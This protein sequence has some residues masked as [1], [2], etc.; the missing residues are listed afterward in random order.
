M[1]TISVVILNYNG[2]KM[3][4]KYL[5][6]VVSNTKDAEIIVA[7]N[8]ST[9]NSITWIKNNYPSIRIIEMSE[10]WGFAEGYNKALKQVDSEYFILLNS[11][12][13]TPEGWLQPLIDYLKNNNQCGACQPKIL[14]DI[15]KNKFEYAGAAGGYIDYFGYPFCRGRIFDYVE[16][17]KGQYDDIAEIFWASGAC[18]AIKK[19]VFDSIGG[20][21]G[22]F[23]AH[24]EEIDLCWR[25]KSLGYSIACIPQS[26]VY[27]LGG[28][29]LNYE[30]PR[31][32]FLNFR[33]N[34]ILLYK[35][36]PTNKYIFVRT[37][38]IL[39]DF[40][41]S[42]QMLLQGK[43]ANAKAV[44]TGNI[45]FIKMKSHFKA[46]KKSISQSVTCKKPYG[47]LNHLLLWKVYINKNKTFN[48]L[49]F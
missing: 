24:Q 37:V 18:L 22:R 47:I 17:D 46:S 16:T 9:D 31:K 21:D 35:N 7:D 6:S 49:K 12:V 4:E 11:D 48:Q 19:S 13:Y 39:L 32:T 2:E 40:I 34:A 8:K 33:N 5:P 41:A 43:T 3:L 29:S 42:I 38:R 1:N 20:F 26:K 44:I 15:D 36:L 27:H 23:F 45:E 14:S 30:S 10:N 28:G 25:L